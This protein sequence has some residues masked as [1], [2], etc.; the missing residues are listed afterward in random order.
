[1]KFILI[2][3]LIIF[4]TPYLVRLMAPFLM[5]LFFKRMQKNMEQQMNPGGNQSTVD[6]INQK[7]SSS[8]KPKESKEK[9]GDYVDFEEIKE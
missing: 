3:L 1:M 7:P 9:L 6:D 8:S 4:I 2:I 5:R